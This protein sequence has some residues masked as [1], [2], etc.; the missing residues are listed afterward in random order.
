MGA[1]RKC[2]ALES[3]YTSIDKPIYEVDEGN[4]PCGRPKLTVKLKDNTSA[5]ICTSRILE[6]L[7]SALGLGKRKDFLD[8]D[9]EPGVEFALPPQTAKYRTPRHPSAVLATFSKAAKASSL[10]QVAS[11]WQRLASTAND[12]VGNYTIC[13][14]GEGHP[15][16]CTDVV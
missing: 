12:M 4:K 9:S 6:L 8:K 15:G 3:R 14:R 16:P 2:P 7:R 13:T 10:Q 1:A 11:R 5:Q